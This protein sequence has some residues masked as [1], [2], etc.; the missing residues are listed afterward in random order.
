MPTT[1]L[2]RRVQFAAAH[3]YRRPEWD[4]A[5]NE[6]VFGKCARPEY[7][8]HSYTC[9]VTLA[10]PIE[11]KTGMIFDLGVFD[12][13]LAREV[14]ERFDHRNLNTDVAEFAEGLD[15]PTCENLARVI[16][17]RVQLGIGDCAVV[18]TVCVAESP[19]L[20]ATWHHT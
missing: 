4:D 19:T 5:T 7:H 6:R 2:T 16:A 10:G 12:A 15:I 11:S 1:S 20:W 13:V 9:D 17:E 3:R 8:G 18:T 14:T